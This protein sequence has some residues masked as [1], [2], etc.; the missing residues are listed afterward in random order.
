MN[1]FKHSIGRVTDHLPIYFMW[2]CDTSDV[3]IALWQDRWHKR[4]QLCIKF[5]TGYMTQATSIV[6]FEDGSLLH[7]GN[8][9]TIISLNVCRDIMI[10]FLLLN[11]T[12]FSIHAIYVIFRALLP[13]FAQYNNSTIYKL[14]LLDRANYKIIIQKIWGSWI[15][16][17]RKTIIVLW[18]QE[19]H[20]QSQWCIAT[21]HLKIIAVPTSTNVEMICFL[22]LN[23]TVFFMLCT[24][25]VPTFRA[26]LFRWAFNLSKLC[27]GNMSYSIMVTML[28][29]EAKNVLF[30]WSVIE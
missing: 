19:W 26:L 8:R 11:L 18:W 21:S 1:Y 3:N 12:V 7:P 4:H 17:P 5:V 22:L 9:L 23:L 30:A 2:K 24:N 16:W 27:L 6:H 15:A 20:K 28:E 13:S 29:G 25:A 14:P 10:S